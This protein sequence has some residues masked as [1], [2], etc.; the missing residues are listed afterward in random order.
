MSGVAYRLTEFI[1][2]ENGRCLIVDTSAGLSLGALPG[3]EH[4][5][6]S[7][8]PILPLVDGLVCS[9]GQARQI[10]KRN[11]QEAGLLIRMDWSNTLRGNDFVLPT[12]VPTRLPI[13]TPSDA[14]ELG[15]AGMV[16]TFLLGYE[17]EIE[18]DCLRSTVQWA[19][20]GKSL[21]IPLVVEVQATGARVSL[22]GK[23]V[24][25]GVS[26]ALE[27]GAD[28]IVIPHPGRKSL[29]TIASFVCVPWLIKAS[30]P[31]AALAEAEE[32]LAAGAAGLWLDHAL[33]AEPEPA[34]LAS[35]LLALIHNKAAA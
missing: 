12:A 17:E 15:A 5:T 27:G 20:E 18:A 14:L 32:G 25:L 31:Q 21:G 34:G 1:R 2:P 26:Y 7:I 16:S 35:Q 19:L 4:F 22:P 33:F 29:E 28:V 30:S 24:E 9:P 23:A 3:L 13:L 11:R 10:P 6:R 8:T